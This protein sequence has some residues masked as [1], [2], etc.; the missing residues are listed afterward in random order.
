MDIADCYQLLELTSGASFAEIK[1][2]YRRL[3]QQY[4]PDTNP[5]EEAKERFIALTVAYKLLVSE[6]Q[7]L[8]DDDPVKPEQVER[9]NSDVTPQ[10]PWKTKITRKEKPSQDT[11]QLSEDE[12]QLKWRSYN[13]LQQLLKNQTF[14]KA[15][16]LVENLARRL[17][18]DPEVRSWQANAYHRWGR[19]LVNERQ[20]DKARIF[21]KK[22][23]KTDPHNRSLWSEV[24]RDFRRIEQI[25]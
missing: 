1:A 16:A 18:Q 6:Q 24:E 14:P 10:Q 15:I 25:F 23:L 8:M 4:H 13:Q 17:P 12:K 5:G 11:P 7:D 3:A 20:L 21:L 19:Q 9:R 2:A 22:A